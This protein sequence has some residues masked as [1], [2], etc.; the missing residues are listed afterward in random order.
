MLEFKFIEIIKP[1]IEVI[2]IINKCSYI[3]KIVKIKILN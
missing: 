3:V 1:N 2:K